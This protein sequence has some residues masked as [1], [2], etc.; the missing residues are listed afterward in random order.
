MPHPAL[1]AFWQ[2]PII[3]YPGFGS[4]GHPIKFF[5]SRHLAH[6]FV[7]A[8]NRVIKANIKA[9]LE[10]PTK[11]YDGHIRGYHGVNRITL[12]ASDLVPNGWR[13]HVTPPHSDLAQAHI[14]PYGFLEVMERDEGLDDEHGAPSLSV[15]FLGADGHATYDALFCQDGRE[16]PPYA[17]VLQDHGFGGNYS[18]FGRGGLLEQ[19]AI[20]AGVFPEYLFVAENT[21]PWSGYVRVPD[22]EGSRGGM[23]GHLRHLYRRDR[24]V[25]T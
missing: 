10:N 23:H 22:V 14:K 1:D 4:D 20:R 6:H 25:V 2:S 19:I 15:L 21:E 9:D 3:F 13:P 24:S 5:N 11:S 7:Y 16:R 17:V 12:Q 18:N 8:D